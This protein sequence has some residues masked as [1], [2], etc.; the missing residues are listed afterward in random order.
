MKS[1]RVWGVD[2][3]VNMKQIAQRT[4]TAT[5]YVSMCFLA[6]ANGCN[7]NSQTWCFRGASGHLVSFLAGVDTGAFDLKFHVPHKG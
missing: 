3:H 2:P 6:L 1:L 4:E 5:A 7:S